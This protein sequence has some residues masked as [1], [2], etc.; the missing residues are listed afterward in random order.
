MNGKKHTLT[1]TDLKPKEQ[2]YENYTIEIMMRF[3]VI[4]E[5]NFE[6]K[7][8]IRNKLSM[9]PCEYHNFIGFDKTKT[10]CKAL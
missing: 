10:T 3:S 5:T 8:S 9:N 6:F 7:T 4:N 2:Q 1:R